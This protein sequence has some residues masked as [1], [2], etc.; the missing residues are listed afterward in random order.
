MG[1]GSLVGYFLG[2]AIILLINRV[3]LE[4]ESLY[5]VLTL[6]LVLF[7][8]GIAVV[9][10]GNG[11]L[12]VY[13]AG[14]IVGNKDFIH[15][16]TLMK[17]HEGL[18]WLMQIAMFLTLGLLVYP[19]KIV[20]IMGAGLLISIFLMVIARPASVFLSLLFSRL[21]AREK[22]MVSWVGLRGAVPIIL[23][24][25]PLLANLPR[26]TSYLISYFLLCSHQ[27]CCREARF[28]GFRKYSASIRP[29][30]ITAITR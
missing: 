13:L 9:V 16:K 1:I 15:K 14:L 25:F 21:R 3:K 11:F 2:K 26:A 23:A 18:A 4:Y 19:A 22:L 10:K 29:T 7:T 24:T 28:P 20:P 27:R 8:Y 30:A 12:A 5:P 6:A 17:F